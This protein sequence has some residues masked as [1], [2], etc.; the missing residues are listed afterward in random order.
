VL[1]NFI[2]GLPSHTTAGIM[3]GQRARYQRYLMD[4]EESPEFAKIIIQLNLT[5]AV[6]L[7]ATDPR[8]HIFALLSMASDSR[9]LGITPN[10]GKDCRTVYIETARALLV[11]GHMEI[12]TFSQFSNLEADMPSWVPDWSRS[13]SIPPI[14]SGLSEICFCP[15]YNSSGDFSPGVTLHSDIDMITLPAI[16]VGMIEDIGTPL[17]VEPGGSWNIGTV[18]DFLEELRDFHHR[19]DSMANNEY[20]SNSKRRIEVV[21]R[22]PVRDMHFDG[23][24][25]LPCRASASMIKG[26]DALLE[27][28]RLSKLSRS[29]TISPDNPNPE[30]C[31]KAE[32]V[33]TESGLQP[34]SLE[35]L[36]AMT[37]SVGKLPFLT[38]TGYVGLGPATTRAGDKV[39][40]VFGSAVPYVFRPT[41]DR[42]HLLLGPAYVYGIMDGEFLEG[43][44]VVEDLDVI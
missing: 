24:S 39:Y 44:I 26:Y 30:V 25:G 15:L 42:H 13:R 1:K 40:I 34:V 43:E 3:I 32:E 37:L 16:L 2:D 36:S 35:Y 10:Y 8:D 21:R 12:L 6:T 7:Q 31:V 4:Y 9:A 5:S 17:T 18:D 11:H 14:V 28:I 23:T 33:K 20:S 38:T 41:E 22:T 27:D 19:S 29:P